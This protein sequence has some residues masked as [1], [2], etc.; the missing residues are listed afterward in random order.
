MSYDDVIAR[1]CLTLDNATLRK[2]INSSQLAAYDN[3]AFGEGHFVADLGKKTQASVNNSWSYV[4]VTYVAFTKIF[5]A[6]GRRFKYIAL[7]E[8]INCT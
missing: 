4:L 1:A 6:H 3:A 8:K 2:K 7:R 5:F